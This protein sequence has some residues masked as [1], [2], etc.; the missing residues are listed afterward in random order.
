MQEVADCGPIAKTESV[1]STS[2]ISILKKVLARCGRWWWTRAMDESP[3]RFANE[4]FYHQEFDDRTRQWLWE[5]AIREGHRH[6]GVIVDLI[7]Q[8][9]DVDAFTGHMELEFL[10]HLGFE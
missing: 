4:P 5:A 6:N 1:A 3:G 10:Q 8:G 2:P 9:Y 7:K